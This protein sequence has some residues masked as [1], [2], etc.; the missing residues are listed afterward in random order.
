MNILR[1]I[2]STVATGGLMLALASPAVSFA[3][4]Q[5]HHHWQ[6]QERSSQD[7]TQWIK[8]RLTREA[9]MLEI[10]ASQQSAW[11]TYSAAALELTSTYGESK[12]LPSNPDAAAAMR[13]VAEQ[14]TFFA[15]RMGKLAD[16]TEKLQAVLNEDQRKVLDRIVMLH[17]QHEGMHDRGHWQDR[18]RRHDEGGMSSGNSKPSPKAAPSAKP[19]N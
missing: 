13:L 16:A 11:E 9:A 1:P 2:L 10:K 14:A 17:T 8:N 19:K 6:Q 12:A 5:E 15:Q 18:E 7:R 3:H 4:D